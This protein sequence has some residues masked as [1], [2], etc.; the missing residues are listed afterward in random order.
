MLKM[1]YYLWKNHDIGQKVFDLNSSF[2]ERILI[3]S[4]P[5]QDRPLFEGSPFTPGLYLNSV[6][7]VHLWQK[8][9]RLH[10]LPL[11]MANKPEW[12]FLP[13]LINKKNTIY[14]QNLSRNNRDEAEFNFFH[15]FSWTVEPNT[16]H[17][18]F[19]THLLWIQ[20]KVS[21]SFAHFL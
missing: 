6:F 19:S 4:T 1:N 2:P 7:Y 3:F 8:K 15:T 13:F 14:S 17:M 10:Q 21:L 12:H 9:G 11:N 5:A 18:R 16:I 20:V